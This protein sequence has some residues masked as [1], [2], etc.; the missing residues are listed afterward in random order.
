[1]VI[2]ALLDRSHSGVDVYL[3]RSH[4]GVD[5]YLT[6]QSTDLSSGLNS[7]E[8]SIL[9]NSASQ[10]D[11]TSVLLDQ[12]RLQEAKKVF[13]TDLILSTSTT[14]NEEEATHDDDDLDA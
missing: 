5:V 11:N 1:M 8:R 6:S 4:S 3:D 12:V 13:R 2:R 10:V 7:V 9:F 14:V